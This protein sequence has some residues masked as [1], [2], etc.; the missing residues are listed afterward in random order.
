MPTST[1]SIHT[2]SLQ[3]IEDQVQQLLLTEKENIT[4]ATIKK[5]RESIK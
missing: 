4:E 3:E 1:K 2:D 5:S